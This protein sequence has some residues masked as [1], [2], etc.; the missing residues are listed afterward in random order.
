MSTAEVSGSH[1]SHWSSVTSWTL[2][3]L[4]LATGALAIA[5]VH[6]AVEL[7]PN[8]GMADPVALVRAF[9]RFGAGED[10][11]H[12]TLPLSNLRGVSDEALNAGGSVR[13]DLAAGLIT[14]TVQLLPASDVRDRRDRSRRRFLVRV[15]ECRIRRALHEFQ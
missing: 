4:A 15:L 2:T 11:N 6:A 9:D 10:V 8:T 14:S 7:S 12:L 3:L 13:I 5:T 1:P